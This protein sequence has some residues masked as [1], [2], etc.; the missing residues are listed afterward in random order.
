[1]DQKYLD[2]KNYNLA[3]DLKLNDYVDAKDT[4]NHWCVANI[5]DIDDEKN[6]IKVHFEGWTHRYDEVLHSYI[7]KDF[8]NFSG[9]RRMQSTS[10]HL[11]GDILKAILARRRMLIEIGT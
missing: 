8:F 1:M 3:P 9:L 11:S 5:I 2:A 10:Q 4:V 6:S 7:F